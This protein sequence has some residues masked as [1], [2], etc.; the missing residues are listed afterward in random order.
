[1]SGRLHRGEGGFTLIEMMVVISVIVIL[2]GIAIPIYSRSINRAKE[3]AFERNLQTLN[4]LIYEYT[5][6][7][8]KAP[9]GLDDLVQAG[10]IDKIPVDITGSESWEVDQDPQTIMVLGQNDGG[11]YG[12]HSG[13]SRVGSN[14]KPYKDW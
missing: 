8:Q 13:S 14:G 2:L 4:K 10:Y 6:D 1:M 9:Q 5:L 3:D 7:K 12:V 11:V